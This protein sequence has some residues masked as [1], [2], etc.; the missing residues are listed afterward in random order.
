MKTRIAFTPSSEGAPG[1][2]W[3]TWR[4]MTRGG[5][6]VLAA[7]ILADPGA[8]EAAITFNF[9]FTDPAGTGWNDPTYGLT[10]Q[11]TLLYAANT[12]GSY[13]NVTATVGYTVTA[14]TDPNTDTLAS[15]DSS[16]YGTGAPGFDPPDGREPFAGLGNHPRRHARPAI[17]RRRA[18]RDHPATESVCLR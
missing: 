13:F 17:S 18:E 1:R 5:M 15:A 7:V 9:S 4:G 3:L 10:R 6:A 8:S 11:S 14:I 2:R 16:P 12:L